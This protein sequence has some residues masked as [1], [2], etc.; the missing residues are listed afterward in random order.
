MSLFFVILKWTFPWGILIE[1][2]ADICSSYRSASLLPNCLWAGEHFHQSTLLPKRQASR[3]D[4]EWLTN[5]QMS[6]FAFNSL[7]T[8][9]SWRQAEVCDCS[10]LGKR[11]VI[12]PDLATDTACCSLTCSEVLS[13]S[14]PQ[15]TCLH[16]FL[17]GLLFPIC[18][19]LCEKLLQSP[20]QM[21]AAL[22]LSM[23]SWAPVADAGFV[24]YQHVPAHSFH[25][26]IRYV[27]Y[28]ALQRAH[29][30]FNTNTSPNVFLLTDRKHSVSQNK[31]NPSYP[32]FPCSSRQ[33]PGETDEILTFPSQA[34]HRGWHRGGLHQA[35][36][37]ATAH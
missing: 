9:V 7:S 25:R 18:V 16:L 27:V 11:A 33:T 2:N 35:R 23:Q 37:I 29:P 6:R 4:T 12:A 30:Q 32:I 3:S 20:V 15:G 34:A 8:P 5:F 19:I 22:C 36:G 31:H 17:Q 14:N 1:G 13:Q 24:Q 26:Q 28:K 21:S 10:A